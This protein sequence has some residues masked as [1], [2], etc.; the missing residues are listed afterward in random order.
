MMNIEK[1]FTLQNY[2]KYLEYANKNVQK[3]QKACFWTLRH[4]F[5]CCSHKGANVCSG[6]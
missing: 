2:Y 1:R 4:V 6:W 3:S 5:I